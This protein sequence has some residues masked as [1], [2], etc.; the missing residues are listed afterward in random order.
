MARDR[1][2]FDYTGNSG[3]KRTVV[4]LKEKNKSFGN[5]EIFGSLGTTEIGRNCTNG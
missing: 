1:K 3:P 5:E 4:F 2:V